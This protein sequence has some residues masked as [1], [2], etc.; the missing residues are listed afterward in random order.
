LRVKRTQWKGGDYIKLCIFDLDG[1]I[2]DTAKYHYLAWKKL[3]DELGIA[4]TENDNERLKGV[5]CVESLDIL[6]A[7]GA[8]KYTMTQREVWADRGR[9]DT[10]MGF[11]LIIANNTIIVEHY[12]DGRK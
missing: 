12:A 10:Q 9:T 8:E 1:V 4:F 6:L 11:S 2:C 7:L 3:A 5:S